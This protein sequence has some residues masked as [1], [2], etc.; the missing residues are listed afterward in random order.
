M[1]PEAE[2]ITL[3]TGPNGSGKTTVLEAV[4]FLST[5]RPLMGS[6]PE[7]MVRTGTER[8]V[9]RAKLDRHGRLVT[10]E[11][12]VAR[13]ERGRVR[14]NG[15]AV[16][17]KAQRAEAL[18]VTVFGPDQLALVQGGPAGRRAFLDDGLR[19]LD[20][21]AGHAL[22]E[23]ERVLRQRNA[24]LRQASGRLSAEVAATL[25]VWDERLARAGATVAAHRGVLVGDLEKPTGETYTHLASEASRDEHVDERGATAS[26]GLQLSY[27]RGWE[28]LLHEAL[29]SARARDLERGATT[30]GPH[31]DEMV[32]ALDGRE[33]RTQASRGEQRCAVL[34]LRLA[35]HGLVTS[36]LGEPPILLLDDVFSELD[37]ARS[38]ALVSAIPPGQA[39]VTS[40]IPVPGGMS[41]RRVLDVGSIGA[42][43]AR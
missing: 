8:A 39:L 9:A 14:V 26:T 31:L 3:L 21:T 12:E 32:V 27:Q 30:R 6:S 18:P 38:L 15:Q 41:V 4:G 33:A 13:G 24:L 1:E 5:G 34:A 40:A 7:G 37:P 28:G 23:M 22:D 2:G 29:A 19:V 36:R 25:D 35:L 43:G 42:G 20:P 11:A 16:R 10:V 17:G